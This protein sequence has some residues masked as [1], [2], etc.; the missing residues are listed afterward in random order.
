MVHWIAWST[1]DSSTPAGTLSFDQPASYLFA[2]DLTG[3][4]TLLNPSS[5]TPVAILYVITGKRAVSIPTIGGATP[6]VT[7]EQK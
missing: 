3:R 6:V 5:V 2:E 4:V 1:I 7:I